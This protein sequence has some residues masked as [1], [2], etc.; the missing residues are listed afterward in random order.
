MLDIMHAD[1]EPVA[2]RRVMKLVYTSE[3]NILE[4]L[5]KY[6]FLINSAQVCIGSPETFC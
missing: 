1:V 4:T 5:L 2:E 6:E 3:S